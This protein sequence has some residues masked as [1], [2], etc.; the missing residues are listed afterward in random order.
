M[1]Q[2]RAS[3]HRDSILAYFQQGFVARHGEPVAAAGRDRIEDENDRCHAA[4]LSRKRKLPG[5]A[6]D[7]RDS[8]RRARAGPGQT[9]K[10]VEKMWGA[11]NEVAALEALGA[12]GGLDEVASGNLRAMAAAIARALGE[13]T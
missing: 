4:A 1:V 6:T 5:T 7:H 13:G 12:G 9:E 10:A 11:F 2:V 8:D 3:V